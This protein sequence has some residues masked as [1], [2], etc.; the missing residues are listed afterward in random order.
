MRSK[1]TYILLTIAA[2]II[3]GLPMSKADA[4]RQDQRPRPI[5]DT[6]YF[7][8]LDDLKSAWKT[9][10]IP[11]T[12]VEGTLGETKYIILAASPY[13]G[14]NSIDVYCYINLQNNSWHL[15]SVAFLPPSNVT[16][17]KTFHVQVTHEHDVIQVWHN[18]KV[19]MTLDLPKRPT[20]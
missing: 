1:L 3:T 14:V 2:A 4:N 12:I 5:E 18:D 10:T 7:A 15:Y 8:T 9:H 17:D 13:S 19:F 20:K 11:V 16:G 6:R